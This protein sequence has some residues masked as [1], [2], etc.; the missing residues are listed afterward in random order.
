[1]TQEIEIRFALPINIDEISQAGIII[2]YVNRSRKKL[3]RFRQN[4]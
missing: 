1:M 3:I 4:W 2:G